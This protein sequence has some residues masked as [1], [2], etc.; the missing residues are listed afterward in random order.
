MGKNTHSKSST[1]CSLLCSF[2]YLYSV[3]DRDK[4]TQQELFREPED[5]EEC[6]EELETTYRKNTLNQAHHECFFFLTTIEPAQHN[7]TNYTGTQRKQACIIRM[8]TK[9]TFYTKDEHSKDEKCL[10]LHNRK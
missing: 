4:R 1:T 7:C 2:S 3:K 9:E 8:N 5:S 10:G 6:L